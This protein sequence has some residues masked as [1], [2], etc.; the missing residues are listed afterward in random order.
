MNKEMIKKYTPQVLFLKASSRQASYSFPSRQAS[1]SFPP[2]GR[3][4]RR[5]FFN[6]F[7]LNYLQSLGPQ[8]PRQASKKLFT[9]KPT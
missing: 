2:P 6:F 9:P 8:A 1:Y 4:T 3:F 5:F 7:L